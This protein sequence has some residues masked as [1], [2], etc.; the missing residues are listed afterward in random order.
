MG[1]AAVPGGSAH[2]MIGR[3][4]TDGTDARARG[5][6]VGGG[7]FF[8]GRR[9]SRLLLIGTQMSHITLS[10]SATPFLAD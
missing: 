10:L 3:A 6:R 5:G 2:P 1:G 8:F 9:F 7:L 4:R